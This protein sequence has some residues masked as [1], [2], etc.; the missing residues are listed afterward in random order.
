[1]SP[2]EITALVARVVEVA[3]EE[4]DRAA[5]TALMRDIRRV[6]GW[7]DAVEI[8]A[9]RQIKA[10][11]VEGRAEPAQ[12][13]L[14]GPGG[15][16]GSEAKEACEREEIADAL[17]GF[18]RALADGEVTAGHLG[19]LSA[20]AKMLAAHPEL[21]GKFRDHERELLEV[22]ARERV[23]AFRSRCRR[24]AKR[25][26][27]EADAGADDTLA[28]QRS[29]AEVRTWWDQATG[30]WHLHAQLDPERGSL[31]DQCLRQEVERRRA[32]DQQTGDAPTQ[33][34]QLK[35]DALVSAVQSEAA[36][37]VRSRVSLSVHVDWEWLRGEAGSGVCE[38][39]DGV[40][41]PVETVRRLAC[42]AE[43]LPAVMGGDALVKD[44]GRA[45]RTATPSQRARLATMHATCA[46]P[47][48]RVPFSRCRVHHVVFWGRGGSTDEDNLIPVCEQ[49]HRLLH[50]GGWTLDLASDRVGTWRLP[51]GTVYWR[52][53]TIDRRL[54]SEEAA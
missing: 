25:L 30:M 32:Q 49:H 16:S 24:L 3:P 13:A 38:T 40:E 52:G 45:V 27:A 23:D 36:D 46:H 28:R 1:M 48:C 21:L 15:H 20:A 47:D 14:S 39:A 7:L 42:D 18:E 9:T 10:L 33:F 29:R 4:L 17:P 37:G 5:C 43:V 2:P 6:R 41:L 51:D 19:A 35:V 53:P 8:R 11:A 26:I 22:A 12:S 50:E 31:V 44:M 34:M 54:D